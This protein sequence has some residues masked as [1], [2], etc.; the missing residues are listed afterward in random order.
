MPKP[1]LQPTLLT[2][3]ISK[4]KLISFADYSSVGGTNIRYQAAP[5]VMDGRFNIG[6]TGGHET[7]SRTIIVPSLKMENVDNASLDIS[8]KSSSVD[9]SAHED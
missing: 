3:S 9:L 7:K 8:Q 1:P 6:E 4:G 5:H 2:Q